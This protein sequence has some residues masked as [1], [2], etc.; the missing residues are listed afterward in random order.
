MQRP[1]LFDMKQNNEP[2]FIS[3][4]LKG[5]PGILMN[6]LIVLSKWQLNFG[7]KCGQLVPPHL[8]LRLKP[9]TFSQVGERYFHVRILSQQAFQINDLVWLAYLY[10]FQRQ[11]TLHLSTKGNKLLHIS[12]SHTFAC[13]AYCSLIYRNIMHS[14]RYVENPHIF[15]MSQPC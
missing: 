13:Y 12:L 7:I 6:L 15:W 11:G 14:Q 1:F 4:A 3:M 8:H 10:P 9:F 5:T 2:V